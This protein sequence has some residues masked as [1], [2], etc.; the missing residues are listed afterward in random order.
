M[1]SGAIIVIGLGLLVLVGLFAAGLGVTSKSGSSGVTAESIAGTPGE[2]PVDGSG[3]LVYGTFRTN[4][5][6]KML[7]I[8]VRRPDYAASVGFV[9]P[10]GCTPAQGAVLV[11]GGPC[12]RVPVAGDVTGG[13]T[14][15]SGAT[16]VIVQV[17]IS[18]DCFEELRVGDPWPSTHPGCRPS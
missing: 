18:N 4:A 17:P 1:K 16:L 3:A 15:R 10:A 6:I 9:P 12:A 8:Q 7:G 14:T 2:P 5:G 11:A 13:G